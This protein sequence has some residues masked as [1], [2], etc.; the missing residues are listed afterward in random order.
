MQDSE[1]SSKSRFLLVEVRGIHSPEKAQGLALSP[2]S[3]TVLP[4]GWGLSVSSL[5]VL[6]VPTWVSSGYSGFLPQ[7]DMW[8]RLTGDFKLLSSVNVGMNDCLVYPRVLSGVCF[9]VFKWC[10]EISKFV[11]GVKPNVAKCLSDPKR[12]LKL[13]YKANISNLLNNL[14]LSIQ[15]VKKICVFFEKLSY[16][17]E[18]CKRE[19][20]TYLS[21]WQI[22]F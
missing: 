14:N 20:P 15:E 9:A 10:S 4:A 21:S 1:H 13:A 19:S 5:Y 8:F 22:F 18:E 7:S 11:K 3:K 12:L 6:S 17:E 2:Q 16:G